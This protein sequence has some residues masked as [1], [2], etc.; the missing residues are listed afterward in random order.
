ML[1]TIL[2]KKFKPQKSSPSN[3]WLERGREQ[4]PAEVSGWIHRGR[5]VMNIFL[6]L[7]PIHILNIYYIYLNIYL[8]ILNIYYIYFY[9]VVSKVSELKACVSDFLSNIDIVF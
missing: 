9:T 5:D 4:L 8:N 6:P 7:S 3:G 1:T 2:N